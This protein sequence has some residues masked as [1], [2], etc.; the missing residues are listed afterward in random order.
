MARRR[1]IVRTLD[2]QPRWIR[3]LL[4]IPAFVLALE[5]GLI[6]F[7]LV[8]NGNQVVARHNVV[9]S[10]CYRD[11]AG[12]WITY[13]CDTTQDDSA[14]LTPLSTA[15]RIKTIRPLHGSIEV[16]TRRT[17][18]AKGTKR[19][20]LVKQGTPRYS[21]WLGLL[22]IP[23]CIGTFWILYAMQSKL[24]RWCASWLRRSIT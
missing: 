11:P 7:S 3:R 12:G 23:A 10:R 1:R 8:E 18:G 22:V 20:I 14:F 4:A 5:A 17:Q 15:K 24:L 6:T 9:V 19:L 2:Q 13:L 16:E 21:S